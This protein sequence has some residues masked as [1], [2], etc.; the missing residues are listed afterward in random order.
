VL[1]NA[2][3]YGDAQALVDGL[4][5]DQLTYAQLAAY[6]DRVAAGLTERGLRPGETVAVFSPNTIWYPV[7]FHGI[8]AAGALSSTINSLYTPDEIAFQLKD[9][10]PCRPSW[11]G[12]WPRRRFSRSRRSS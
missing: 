12:H 6:V 10:S 11:T 4:T 8:A 3:E 5:G 7:L 2:G 9:S 1:R